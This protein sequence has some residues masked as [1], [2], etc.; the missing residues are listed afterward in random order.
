MSHPISFS[1][2]PET[3]LVLERTIDVPVERVWAAW[4]VPDQLKRWFTPAPWSTVDAE[5]DLRPGGMFRTVMRSPEGQDFPSAG[6]YL[7]VIENKRLTFTNVLA[8]GFRPHLQAGPK[9]CDSIGFTAVVTMERQE[10]STRYV[11]LAMHA[12]ADNRR[13]HEEMGFHEGW[14]KALDQLVAMAQGQ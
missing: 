10:G 14:G 7:E 11:V 4:T 12:D 1:A 6:C 13:R 9:E 2:N 5:L 8:P 3:D